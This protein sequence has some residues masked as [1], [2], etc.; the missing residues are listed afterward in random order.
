MCAAYPGTPIVRF[1][2][3]ADGNPTPN[4]TTSDSGVENT[5][6]VDY[7]TTI[8]NV[9]DDHAGTYYCSATSSEFPQDDA[10]RTFRFYVGGTCV[11]FSHFFK[12][13]TPDRI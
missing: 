9:V 11:V 1:N 13:N 2:C 6:T 8:S 12:V 7:V 4:L 3:S 10:T 5:N